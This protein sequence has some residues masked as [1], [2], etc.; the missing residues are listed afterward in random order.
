MN[1]LGKKSLV[2]YFSHTGEN[3]MSDGI[4]NIDKGNTEVIAEMIKDIT[5]ADLFKVE[6]AID[7]PYNYRECV[8]LAS[9]EKSENARPKLKKYLDNID[10]YE[11]I[12]IGFPNFTNKIIKPFCTNEGSRM[13][14]SESDIKKIC[15]GATVLEGLPIQGSVVYESKNK[16]ENWIK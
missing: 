7:Y 4:R 3:Y 15:K 2:I 1:L 11:V 14:S 5:K 16:V 9:K 6:K 12:Y 8:D 10:D 13:G